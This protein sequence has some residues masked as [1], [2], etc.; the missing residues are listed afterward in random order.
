VTDRRGGAAACCGPSVCLACALKVPQPCLQIC[1][2]RLTFYVMQV[3]SFGVQ[4]G[5][6]RLAEQERADALSRAAD[7]C[8]YSF[9]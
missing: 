9:C 3:L 2:G 1:R 5:L 7:V 4:L 6:A 8:L